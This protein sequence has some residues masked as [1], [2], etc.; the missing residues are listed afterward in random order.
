MNLTLAEDFSDYPPRRA[1]A[2]HKGTFGHLAIVA[3]SVGYHGAAVLA[4]RGAQRAQ[5]GLVTLCVLEN[6]YAPVA[7][8]LQAVMVC[9]FVATP[10]IPDSCTA[11]LCGPGLASPDLPASLKS[12][13]VDLWQT[14]P[15]PMVVDASALDWL[16]AGATSSQALR[17]LTP[18][19]GEA[20]RLLKAT[21]AQVQA[22]RP[23]ALRELSRRFG[24]CWV[25]LKGHQTLIGRSEG[26][27][28]INSSGNPYQAQGGGGD[29]LAGFV[30]GLL[31]QP[32]LHRDVEKVLRYAVWQHGTA[33][34]RLQESRSNWTVENLVM[35]LGSIGR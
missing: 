8:Q 18:H 9:P 22:D 26:K 14:S 10:E 7:A 3:G 20:A 23:T 32:E 17:V 11:I 13:I 31:A 5:P 24:N 28:F 27:M 21:T 19:P 29:V 15:L 30:G 12:H 6:I 25:I 1:V 33:A 34:D 2:A 16:P 35:V 4:A